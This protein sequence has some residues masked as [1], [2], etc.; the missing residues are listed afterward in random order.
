MNLLLITGEEEAAEE[1]RRIVSSWDSCSLTI[2]TSD[3]LKTILGHLTDNDTDAVI[4]DIDSSKRNYLSRIRESFSHIPVIVLSSIN[5][6][7]IV[8]DVFQSGAQDYIV[9]EKTDC[10]KFKKSLLYAVKRQRYTADFERFFGSSFKEIIEKIG[11]GIVVL[12][13][14]GVVLLANPAA[15][16]LF[17]MDADDFIGEL[18]G[19]PVI[20]GES[21]EIEIL[22]RNSEIINVEMRVVKAIL[23][24]KE[25]SIATLRDITKH[26]RMLSELRAM[27]R[28]LEKKAQ[29]EIE[30]RKLEEQ[31]LIQQTRLAAMGEM[32]GVIAHQWRQP[33]NGLGL[34]IQDIDDAFSYDELNKEYLYK[35]TA[36]S[37]ELINYLSSTIDDFSKF[38]KPNKKKEIFDIKSAIRDSLSIVSA[39][40][41]NYLISIKHKCVCDRETIEI[42]DN[43]EIGVCEYGYM[44]TY[45]LPNEFKQAVLN[46]LNNS[47]D[48]ILMQ[49]RKGALGKN[50]KGEIRIDIFHEKEKK[51]IVIKISDNGGGISKDVRKKIFEPYFTT[52]ESM[53]GSG[54]GLYITKVIIVDNMGGEINIENKDSG[55]EFTIALYN[56]T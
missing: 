28:E 35:S 11:D 30:K 49:R 3:N 23:D 17:G 32:V 7:E 12:D 42:Q 16:D 2:H 14:E 50:E 39:R 53:Q 47:I 15:L 40:L 13:R 19:F 24:G 36:K 38:I 45:G 22:N 54:I 27:N 48:A 9:K 4:L 10:K 21:S 6:E 20:G 1:T 41:K 44:N 56:R 29:L 51:K 46:I 26:K 34:I 25:V 18:I 33:L 52:K 8:T 5:D 31:L 37:M 43:L 55:A